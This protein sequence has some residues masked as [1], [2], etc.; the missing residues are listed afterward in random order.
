MYRNGAS[1]E[2]VIQDWA[3]VINCIV[4]SSNAAGQDG[5][6]ASDHTFNLVHMPGDSF[7]NTAGNAESGSTGDIEVA[8]TFVDGTAIGNSDS[9]VAN[10]ALVEGSRGV[11]EGTTF[12]SINVDIIDT[13][14]PQ[15]GSFDI[16]AFEFT[17]GGGGG[18]GGGGSTNFTTSD[19]AET[20][21]LKFGSNS[22]VIHG[23]ANKLA[24]RRFN[25]DKDNRQAPF[26]VTVSGPATIRRRT[27]PYKS[28]T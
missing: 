8:P 15:N 16:G 18:G 23:T 26:S 7:I 3:K 28:E 14:R 20:F 17:S 12:N 13:V 24:T 5:I 9:I 11:D 19:G 4:T 25:S 22:F 6:Q 27:T 1:S 2:P 21:N 10:F